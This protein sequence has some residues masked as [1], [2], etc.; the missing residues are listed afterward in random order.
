LSPDGTFNNNAGNQWQFE[1]PL[2]TLHWA[3]GATEQVVVE[4]GRDWEQ[5]RDAL[6][7]SGMRQEG[8]TVWGKK[9]P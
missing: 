5:K 2:L 9:V 7:F 3:D 4:R 6:V 1:A 8:T